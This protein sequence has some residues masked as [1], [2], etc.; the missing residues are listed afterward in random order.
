MSASLLLKKPLR[1]D[2]TEEEKDEGLIDRKV[3][4]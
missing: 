1:R 2:I 4:A 3:Q